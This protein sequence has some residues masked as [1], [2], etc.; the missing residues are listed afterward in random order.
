MFAG[1]FK[2]MF[3]PFTVSQ[4]EMDK[5]EEFRYYYG[6]KLPNA[7]LTGKDRNIPLTVPTTTYMGVLIDE[8]AGIGSNN[9]PPTNAAGQVGINRSSNVLDDRHVLPNNFLTKDL[10]SGRQAAC[11]NYGSSGTKFGQL[12]DM[13]ANINPTSRV[14]CGWIYNNADPNSGG[15]VYGNIDGPM[16]ETSTSGTWMWDLN[17][18]KK[19]F[20]LYICNQ[21]NSANNDC[22]KLANYPANAGICGYCKSTRKFIPINGSVAAYPGEANNA[23]TASNVVTT[24]SMCPRDPR[25][26]PP[27][28]DSPA[29]AAYVAARGVC[30][31]L[32]NGALTRECLTITAKQAGCSDNGALITALQT[33]SDTNYID[34]LMQNRAYTTYQERSVTGLNATALKTG[35]MTVSNAL[36]GFQDLFKDTTST[37]DKGLK[38]A[39]FDLCVT[40]GSLED[41]DFC[42]E[43][44]PSSI[45]PFSEECLQKAF[46]RA[47]GQETGSLYPNS[48]NVAKWNTNNTWGDVLRAIQTLKDNSASTDRKI[49]QTAIRQ[50]QGIPLDNKASPEFPLNTSGV[51]NVE[52]FWF[53]PDTD[54]K[55]ASTYN[56]IFL[57]RRIRSQIP[58]LGGSSG[59]PGGVNTTGSFVY[60]TNIAVTTSTKIKLEFKGD[61]GFIFA[62]NRGA[63]IRGAPSIPMMNDYKDYDK[64]D[65]GNGVDVANQEL[66]SLY[67]KFGN[68]ASQM[69][70]RTEWT[71]R[72]NVPNIITGYYIG[73]GNNYNIRYRELSDTPE[74]CGCYGSSSADAAIR[75]YSESECNTLGGN[76]YSNG[77]CII[78]SGGSFSA[79][80]KPLNATQTCANVW[81]PIPGQMLYLIQD[82][83]A[84]MISFNVMNAN[85]QARYNCNYAFMDKRLSSHKMKWSIYGGNGPTPSYSADG[86]DTPTYPLGMSFLR[87]VNGSGIMSQFLFKLYS[88][89]T[90]VYIVRFTRLPTSGTQA[91]PFICWS[92]YPSIDYPTIFVV[93]KGT[94]SAQL[95]VGT[96][97]NPTG[98][99]PNTNNYGC[100]SPPK[101]TDG[102][103]IRLGETYV[104]TMNA[105]RTNPSDIY[106]LNSLT[107]GA[108]LLS[109]LQNDPSLLRQSSPVVWTNSRSLE[110]PDAATGSFFYFKGESNCEFDLFSLQMF[111]Y[112][113]T[114]ENLG[115]VANADWSTPAANE[116]T[117]PITDQNPYV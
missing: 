92:G 12:S 109:D 104:I 116:P 58:S 56:T 102:P 44:Q 31:P 75:I 76:Y 19:R 46:K 67:N 2:T 115:H 108:A 95:S 117:T 105:N 51:R 1:L 112:A 6:E 73:N 54:L 27:P 86:S 24:A 62:R 59:I 18:A 93:G 10:L 111:D 84:P 55:G 16:V 3:E 61:S 15:G 50:F 43:L 68:P 29:Y 5:Q 22:T 47:D 69:V 60:F 98:S 53:T 28:P 114:G 45:G 90:L 81:G 39:A 107:I 11:A 70:G 96:F 100:I 41:Y 103:M 101:S 89:T 80:C 8:L 23:C 49:Q 63:L 33:G 78:K 20:H 77:E 17:A 65:F 71:L 26:P 32:T 7:I 97:Q 4:A 34:S 79:G 82:P 106:S 110:N 25:P 87:F 85:Q 99:G 35:K 74:Y 94:N 88:F 36:T 37:Y 113:V 38:A 57:G 14:R 9:G 30:D 83:Y 66:S 21:M 48:N 42:T 64:A 72:P 91:Q 40:K 13:A 52:I